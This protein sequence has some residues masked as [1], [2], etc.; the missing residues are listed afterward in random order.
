MS[1]AT[2]VVDTDTRATSPTHALAQ[3]LGAIDTPTFFR[4]YFG[5]RGVHIA[6]SMRETPLFGWNQLNALLNN[7]KGLPAGA[8][9]L[10]D[11]KETVPLD[12]LVLL[13]DIRRGLTMFVEDI[14]RYDPTLSTFLSDLSRELQSP[15]RFNMYLSSPGQQGRKLHYDTHDVFVVQVE[16]SKRWAIYDITD[17]L[18]IYT[19]KNH[20]SAAPDEATPYL[21]CTL[22]KG[23]VLYLPRGHWHNVNPV[24]EVSLHLTLGVF[25]PNGIEF[26]QWLVDEC[27]EVDA[28]RENIPLRIAFSSDEEYT[29]AR[30]MYTE[31]ILNILTTRARTGHV[32]D[33]Y[34][35]FCTA[36]LPNR[37][38]FNFPFSMAR[39]E[40]LPARTTP[41]RSIDH[42]AKLTFGANDASASLIYSNRVI[43]VPS[44][45][46]VI[47][48][49]MLSGARFT[50][51]DVEGRC[52]SADGPH[53]RSLVKALVAE[54]LVV[55]AT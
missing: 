45:L 23:D 21:D 19:R 51:E 33:E 28:A 50:V 53:L 43:A 46:V 36:S 35:A 31:R 39:E 15:T 16:G 6:G 20:E 41:L 22:R 30:Q 38:P 55:T 5:R 13:R 14:D 7:H 24:D 12:Y 42:N 54:G 4:D 48:R 37:R 17:P 9:I 29:R 25:F 1:T 26:L 10:S 8:K 44:S 47:L 18:P 49:E 32:A 27:T 40:L 11:G 34:E 52:D 3:L 2:T